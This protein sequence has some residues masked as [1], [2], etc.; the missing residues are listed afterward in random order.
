M[1]NALDV[2]SRPYGDKRLERQSRSR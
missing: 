2:A 1:K